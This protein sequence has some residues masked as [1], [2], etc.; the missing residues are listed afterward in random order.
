MMIHF[1]HLNDFSGTLNYWFGF[2]LALLWSTSVISSRLY[3]GYHNPTD[4][5]VG[6]ILGISEIFLMLWLRNWAIDWMIYGG[7]SAPLLAFVLAVLLVRFHPEASCRTPAIAETGLALGTTV[8]AWIGGNFGYNVTKPFVTHYLS[9]FLESRYP[10]TSFVMLM[11][12]L[13]GVATVLFVRQVSKFFYSRLLQSFYTPTKSMKDEIDPAIKYLTYFSISFSV[14]N[15][16][17]LLMLFC[18]YHDP[19]KDWV[20][21]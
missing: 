13:L 8:G 5:I 11:R 18:G 21:L 14:I 16:A 9:A 17:P 1:Y 12:V 6:F 19:T 2:A 7:L 20:Y 3:L 4:A 15:L 10:P